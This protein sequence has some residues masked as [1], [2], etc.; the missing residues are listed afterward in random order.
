[1]K[2]TIGIIVW[3]FAIVASGCGDKSMRPTEPDPVPSFTGTW[4]GTSR[5]ISCEPS[6]GGCVNYPVGHER[7]LDFRL[8][9]SG[10]DV[11]GNLS[12]VK[13]GPLVLPPVFWISGRAES[14]KLTFQPMEVQG[15]SGGS[16]FSRPW[17]NSGRSSSVANSG[18]KAVF[19]RPN[20][21][22]RPHDNN[23]ATSK[24]NMEPSMGTRFWESRRCRQ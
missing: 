3:A 20:A 4:I 19:G 17:T 7:Y 5:V 14:G 22:H 11:T 23:V 6:S 10:D 15:A 9:Q 18:R 24:N 16:V 2:Y 13:G 8:T 1:M 12:P 21:L